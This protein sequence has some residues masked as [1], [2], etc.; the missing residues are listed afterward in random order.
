MDLLSG[1]SILGSGAFTYVLPFL[2]VITI[3]VFVHEMGHF[4]VARFFG[5]KVDV[6]SIGFGR[7]IIGRV[8]Q[9]GTRWKLC[10]IPLGGYVKF[11]GDENASSQPMSQERLAQFSDAE[12]RDLFIAKPVAQR[13]WIVAA[14]PI[15]NFLLAIVVFAG[16]F[17]TFG[18]PVI[19]PRVDEVVAGSPAEVAGLRRGDVFVSVDGRRIE[20]FSEVQRLVATSNGRAIELI[21]RRGV[22]EV[23]L[24]ATARP[25]EIVDRISG[26][27]TIWV[28]G[29]RTSTGP[30]GATFETVD[31]ISALWLG[32]RESWFV[33]D[34]TG[35]FLRDLFIGKANPEE[36]GG[37]IRIAQVS[38]QAASISIYALLSL[39]AVLSVS[40]GLLN[41]FPIPMLD[42]GHL[43]FYAAEAVRG[44][45]LTEK[46]QEIGYRIGFAFV[47]GL[48]IFATWN[49]ISRLF[50]S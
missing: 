21:V 5:V 40:I 31:P 14:G 4:L 22:S 2:V 38:G 7:E 27:H 15:A 37:P 12:R 39:M 17:M 23:T 1:V 16:L 33:V 18:R 48:M 3:V 30:N 43:V 11:A 9:Y 19:E 10:W 42:G 6:F 46:T 26:R 49:D 24:N 45:P 13:A 47:I 25:Q 8:D 41:L 29:V 34:R 20:T 44:R 35:V 28:L 32:A 50:A 36:L